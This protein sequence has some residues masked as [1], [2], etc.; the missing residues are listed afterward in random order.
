M[1]HGLDFVTSGTDYAHSNLISNL[2]AA[3]D[4][5]YHL[6]KSRNNQRTYQNQALQHQEAEKLRTTFV[7]QYLLTAKEDDKML[8]P[9]K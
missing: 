8:H 4:V 7:P 1:Y 5:T 2:T 6:R 9:K 3:L